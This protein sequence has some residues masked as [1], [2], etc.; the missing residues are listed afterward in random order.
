MFNS[1]RAQ[2]QRLVNMRSRFEKR[3]GSELNL[4][5]VRSQ[6]GMRSNRR[7]FAHW[8]LKPR[9][10]DELHQVHYEG[11]LQKLSHSSTAGRLLDFE[12][13]WAANALLNVG[14]H[15]WNFIE[16][17]AGTNVQK[18]LLEQRLE[19]IGEVVTHKPQA[20]EFIASMQT[21]GELIQLETAPPT[22][23]LLP[24]HAVPEECDSY[25]NH[26]LHWIFEFSGPVEQ[27]QVG[28]G[29]HRIKRAV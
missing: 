24:L 13:N 11:V 3:G 2:Y 17:G 1:D 4:H 28:R 9:S 20:P 15:V 22:L 27:V 21:A 7:A 18:R 14:H 25:S 5:R 26:N 8:F 29:K 6:E 12:R 23:P 10:D 19:K 16:P